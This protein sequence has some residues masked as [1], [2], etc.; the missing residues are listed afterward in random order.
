MAI[1]PLA[2]K[3]APAELLIDVAKLERDYYQRRPDVNDPEQLVSFGTSGHRGTSSKGTFTGAALDFGTT[4][5]WRTVSGTYILSPRG[6]LSDVNFKTED[7]S[8]TGRGS[9]QDDGRLLIFLN[10]GSREMRMTGTL[11]RLRLE[12]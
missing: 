10:N 7:E 5:P 3:P 4:A 2:G 8:Y 1:H 9:T 12:P 6:R 11:A